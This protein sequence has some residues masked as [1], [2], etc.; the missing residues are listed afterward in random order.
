MS[1]VINLLFATSLLSLAHGFFM[2]AALFTALPLLFNLHE[3][4]D[5]NQQPDTPGTYAIVETCLAG[6]SMLIGLMGSLTVI[7]SKH[8]QVNSL[9]QRILGTFFFIFF[10][11]QG[12]LMYQ[13]LNFVGILT[14]WGWNNGTD[15][16]KDSTLTGC[17]IARY[18]SLNY[19]EIKTISDCKFNAFDLLNVNE[20]QGASQLVDWS[21]KFNY[22]IANKAVVLTAAQSTGLTIDDAALD[23]QHDCWY[24]GCNEICHPRY[25]LNR[26]WITYG[27]ISLGVYALL[28]V[29][30]FIAAS[31]ISKSENDPEDEKL[32]SEPLIPPDDLED[33]REVLQIKDSNSSSRA[34]VNLRFRM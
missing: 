8:R 3:F 20:G 27:A 4:S 10:L 30:S 23:L 11:I 21:N 28:S 16:C 17:P 29:L 31:S 33:V 26:I 13:R 24:W 5:A 12:F 19:T 18:L 34:V 9:S 32:E 22:D 1:N 15:T 25:K 14:D 7:G 2:V 6:A